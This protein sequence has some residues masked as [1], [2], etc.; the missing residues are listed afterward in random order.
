M[1]AK[2]ITVALEERHA[3]GDPR[4]FSQLSPQE[5]STVVMRAQQLKVAEF[6]S[7]KSPRR[8]IQNVEVNQPR[9]ASRKS[10][11]GSGS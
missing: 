2:F 10:R 9:R 1:D 3:A 6:G 8:A 7:K 4:G 5:Q 11:E